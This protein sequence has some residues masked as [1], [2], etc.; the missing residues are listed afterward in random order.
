MILYFVQKYKYLASNKEI[1]QRGEDYAVKY[2][3]SIDYTI[4][5]QNW[6][7]SRAEIDII[8]LDGEVLVF[9]EV[10]TRAYTYFGQPEEFVSTYKEK[11]ISDAATQYM[12][13][14]T[15][16]WE[17]RF[18]IISIILNEDGSM[19]LEHFKDAWF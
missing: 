5:E 7:F 10:K 15:H 1:G 16:E 3:Q 9:I 11:L 19:N 6:R 8:A 2:L 18:D 12:T 4:L 17:I 13:K 14:I